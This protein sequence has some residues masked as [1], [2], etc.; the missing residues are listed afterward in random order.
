LTAFPETN[1]TNDLKPNRLTFE[2]VHF[3]V[4]QHRTLLVS[5]LISF[6]IIKSL[7]LLKFGLFYLSCQLL[8]Q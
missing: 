8:G 2:E 1:Q 4:Q 3:S 6:A 7:A 5:F